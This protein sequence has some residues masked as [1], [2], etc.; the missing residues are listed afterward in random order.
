MRPI[1]ADPS[2]LHLELNTTVDPAVALI[3]RQEADSLGAALSRWGRFV[4]PVRVSTTNDRDDLRAA[5][6]GPSSQLLCALATLDGITLLAPSK[7]ASPPA[8]GELYRA[9]LHELAHVLMFQRCTPA[10]AAQCRPLPVWIREGMAAFVAEGPPSPNL[11][12]DVAQHP[13]LQ[14]IARADA[15][16]LATD[17]SGCYLAARLLFA[18]W[19]GRFGER[20]FAAL[21]RQMRA[22]Q[23]FG[24]AHQKAVGTSPDAFVAE[25]VTQVQREAKTG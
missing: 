22:G 8:H 16:T 5:A 3:C 18:A 6:G 25:W 19:L 15:K 24:A 20:G 2:Q 9:V 23:G 11:R 14:G 12:R 17:G 21:C 7:W 10:G 13:N 1:D 4:R